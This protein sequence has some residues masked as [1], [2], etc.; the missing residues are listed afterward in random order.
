MEL[1]MLDA[2]NAQT[3]LEEVTRVWVHYGSVKKF[4]KQGRNR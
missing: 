4:V 2:S 3:L 1:T